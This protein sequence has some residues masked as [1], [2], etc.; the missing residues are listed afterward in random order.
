MIEAE[1]TLNNM[2]SWINDIAQKYLVTVRI[3]DCIPWRSKGG[4]A[5]FEIKEGRGRE[6]QILRDLRE[7]PDIVGMEV[8]EPAGSLLR[9]VVGMKNCLFIRI[10]MSAGCFLESAMA[11]GDGSTR[12][13]LLVGSGGSLSQLFRGLEEMGMA[14]ELQSMERLYEHEPVTKKQ[15]EIL[16]LALEKGYF[17]YPRRITMNELAGLCGISTATLREILSRG[18][19]NI[20]RHHF[21]GNS[22]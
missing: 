7:H 22:R 6:L 19:R 1:F 18:E 13:R 9:G 8:N 3:T 4:Q 5:I 21:D 20:L 2:N 14:A 12:F 10:I 17:D 16:R 15:E 11:E